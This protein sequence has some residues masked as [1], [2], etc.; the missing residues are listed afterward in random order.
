M[1]K[2]K[3]KARV[4]V[5]SDSHPTSPE[6]P[7]AVRLVCVNCDKTL[8][9][10]TSNDTPSLVQ[11][12][13]EAAAICAPDSHY[14]QFGSNQAAG[15]VAHP[16]DEDPP[17]LVGTAWRAGWLASEIW[18]SPH[19]GGWPWDPT[20]PVAG[21]YE[22][23]LL[24]N[25]VSIFA[26]RGSIGELYDTIATTGGEVR[27]TEQTRHDI[28]ASVVRHDFDPMA[29]H[30]KRLDWDRDR[31]ITPTP[32]GPSDPA[33]IARHADLPPA[34]QISGW[35]R[36]LAALKHEHRRAAEPDCRD[37]EPETVEKRLV[38]SGCNQEIDEDTCHCGE[39]VS[40]HNQGS[41]HSPVAMGCECHMERSLK[42]NPCPDWKDE[43][44]DGRF[45]P[46]GDS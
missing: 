1:T 32:L 5:R 2:C 29:E 20:R 28:A 21:Q 15:W 14:M 38:C 4:W 13:I 8:P 27:V 37:D 17:T 31:Q 18:S 10:G 26:P 41:G 45:D 35:G 42:L 40:A 25:E 36:D 7:T 33:S 39:A 3:H 22:E 24:H 30:A 11:E 6:D 46:G 34:D 19:S 9:F 12:E 44:P 23:H 43:S 16:P